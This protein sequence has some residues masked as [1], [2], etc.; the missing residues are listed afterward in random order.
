V[1]QSIKTNRRHWL[2][3]SV[4]EIVASSNNISLQSEPRG[5][6]PHLLL[7]ATLAGGRAPQAGVGAFHSSAKILN[8]SFSNKSSVCKSR[9][10][11]ASVVSRT[12]PASISTRSRWRATIRRAAITRR[13]AV[14]RLL[15][16][17]DRK[18]HDRLWNA[19]QRAD[20]GAPGAGA[21][22]GFVIAGTAAPGT[23]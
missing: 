22:A 1:T 13:K 19:C 8:R 23:R 17:S 16:R 15:Y 3:L 20:R 10:H 11:S 12:S 2:G 14:C 6:P 5:A 4:E 21:P 7:D 9:V 18:P